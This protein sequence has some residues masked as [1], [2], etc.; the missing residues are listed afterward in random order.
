MTQVPLYNNTTKSIY[1]TQYKTIYT[2]VYK[3][4]IETLAIMV[5][6]YN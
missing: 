6:E 5:Q 3:N 4:Y 1:N 2:C